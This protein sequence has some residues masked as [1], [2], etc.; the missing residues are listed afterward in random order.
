MEAWLGPGTE[1]SE[2]ERRSILS[3][4]KLCSLTTSSAEGALQTRTGVVEQVASTGRTLMVRLVGS[5]LYD[6]VIPNPRVVI[7]ALAAVRPHAFVVVNGLARIHSQVATGPDR[8][9]LLLEV[10]VQ[11]MECWSAD[12]A[13][14]ALKSGSADALKHHGRDAA[15]ARHEAMVL[16]Q[17]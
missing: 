14:E 9:L 17:A 8:D 5:G 6:D 7:S 16:R 10:T 4:L 13:S 2:P 1:P 11:R 12:G 3:Q 15:R